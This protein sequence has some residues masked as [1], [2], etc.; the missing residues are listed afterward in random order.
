MNYVVYPRF[1]TEHRGDV[2]NILCKLIV[3]DHTKTNS[4]FRRIQAEFTKGTY[5]AMYVFG[6]RKLLKALKIG[7][8]DQANDY[9]ASIEPH[10]GRDVIALLAARY[11]MDK[12]GIIARNTSEFFSIP[13]LGDLLK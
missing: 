9:L 5:A 8:L 10:R 3:G 11:D 2:G 4:R 12:Q 13:L 6:W 1:P 7:D